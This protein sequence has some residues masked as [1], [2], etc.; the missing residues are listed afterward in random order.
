VFMGCVRLFLCSLNSTRHGLM[1]L[2]L[3]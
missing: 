2:L 1:E 3:Y